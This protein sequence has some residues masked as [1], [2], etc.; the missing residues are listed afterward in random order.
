VGQWHLL[1]AQLQ[2]VLNYGQSVASPIGRALI[3]RLSHK[4]EEKREPAEPRPSRAAFD[5]NVASPG[6]QGVLRAGKGV[7][8][9]LLM[10][11]IRPRKKR[12]GTGNTYRFLSIDKRT[13]S[14]GGRFMVHAPIIL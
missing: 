8:G 1:S 14:K 4:F 9:V 5:K 13:K 12:V 7:G 6:A 3:R 11:P 10:K 2:V